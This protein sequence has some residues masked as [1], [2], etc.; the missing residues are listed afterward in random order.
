MSARQAFTGRLG[1]ILKVANLVQGRGLPF[2][3]RFPTSSQLKWSGGCTSNDTR[4]GFSSKWYVAPALWKILQNGVLAAITIIVRSPLDTSKMHQNPRVSRSPQ[5]P[6]PGGWEEVR[7]LEDI[8]YI[9]IY[10]QTYSWV[11]IYKSLCM[12]CIT[13]IHNIY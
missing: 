13:L 5:K 11:Y 4:C 6:W 3:E 12:Y 2:L 9:Y 10:K 1:C 7:N 8:T